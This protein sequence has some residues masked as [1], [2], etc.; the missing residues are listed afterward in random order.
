MKFFLLTV[1][2][3][4]C[5]SGCV[6]QSGSHIRTGEI[7]QPTNEQ[8]VKLYLEEPKNYKVLGLVNGEGSHAFVTDQHRMNVAISRMKKEAA[9][10]GANGVLIQD[11][12]K[13]SAKHGVYQEMNNGFGGKVGISSRANDSI[14]KGI[15]IYVTE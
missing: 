6:I 11:T 1:G 2:V 10:L 7:R 8:D 14:A 9:K 3:A 12:G 13:V 4:L 15:A 5:F